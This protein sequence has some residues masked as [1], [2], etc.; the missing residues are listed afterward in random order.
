MCALVSLKKLH[1][2]NDVTPNIQAEQKRNG[3]TE[4][5]GQGS[6]EDEDEETKKREIR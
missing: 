6:E 2:C 1:Y 4:K 3:E 5:Q